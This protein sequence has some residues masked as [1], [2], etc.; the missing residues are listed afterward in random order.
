MII[1]QFVKEDYDCIFN[2]ESE[3][4]TTPRIQLQIFCL[5]MITSRL[6]LQIFFLIT[7]TKL[8]DYVKFIICTLIPIFLKMDCLS[9]YI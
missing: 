1:F 6:Q 3:I 7:F 5:I 2:F 8:F 9:I 4:T